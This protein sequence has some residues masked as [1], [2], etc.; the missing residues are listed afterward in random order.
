MGGWVTS[1][2]CLNKQAA[3]L[4][5]AYFS[6]GLVV[7]STTRKDKDF[8]LNC[9]GRSL[10]S[11][12]TTGDVD[13]RAL[14]FPGEAMHVTQ[15]PS[16]TSQDWHVRP[17]LVWRLQAQP[18]DLSLFLAG[19]WASCDQKAGRLVLG[20]NRGH[21]WKELACQWLKSLIAFKGLGP[22]ICLC[23]SDLRG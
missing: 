16:T 18:C 22:L 12:P 20:N 3:N 8:F 1:P 23:L 2:P 13:P 5:G 11:A 15:R 17:G 14:T 19:P 9:Q 6:Q 21:Y 10:F 4:Q 7:K